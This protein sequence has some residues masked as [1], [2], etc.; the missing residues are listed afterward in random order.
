ML[1]KYFK[2]F[3]VLIMMISLILGYFLVVKPKYEQIIKSIERR[4]TLQSQGY[5]VKRENLEKAKKLLSLYNQTDSDKI[6]RVNT[7]LPTNP[8]HEEIFTILDDIVS[9]NGLVLNGVN[10]SIPSQTGVVAKSGNDTEEEGQLMKRK[11]PEQVK[12]VDVTVEVLGADYP[13]FKSLIT[14]LES[15][16]RLIDI[17][18][19]NFEPAHG[20]ANLQLRTYFFDK[21]SFDIKRDIKL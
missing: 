8:S 13:G 18:N 9:R 19:V 2:W 12:R 14:S 4:V 7:F 6:A 5:L 10:I 1:N 21:E 11:L 15:N 20:R 3:V 17:I 16:L